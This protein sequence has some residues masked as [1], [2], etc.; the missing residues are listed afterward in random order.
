M[1]NFE[2]RLFSIGLASNK[3][4]DHEKKYSTMEKGMFSNCLGSE[5]I[6]TVSLRQ[7]VHPPN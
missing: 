1:Q 3:L 2:G 4:S 5:K 6:P 7:G